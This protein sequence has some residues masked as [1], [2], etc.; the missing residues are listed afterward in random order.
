MS[1]TIDPDRLG[2]GLA[3]SALDAGRLPRGAALGIGAAAIALG[4]LLAVVL[5]GFHPVKAGAIALPSYLVLTYVA[6]NAVEGSRKAKDRVATAVMTGAFGLVM[7]P[8][9]SL[10]W[11]VISRGSTRM[12]ATFFTE[13]MRN[14]VGEGG[15]I[16]HALIGTLLVTG[17]AT[18]ISVPF[19]LFTAIY[20]VEYA[21]DSR[22]S[23]S[24][25]NMVD[26]M[27]GIPS[28]V[29][30]LFAAALFVIFQ[31]AGARSGFAGAVALAVLMTPVVVRSS[32]EMLRLVQNELREASLAL[33]VPKWKTIYKVVLPTAI[34]GILTGITLAI[35]RV[36]GETAPLLVAAGLAQDT[37]WSLFD[38]RMTTLPVQA[39]YSYTQPTLPPELSIDRAWGAAMVLIIVVAV[40]FSIA[41][42]MATVLK[43][44]GLR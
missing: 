35:A 2:T 26:V 38:G 10:V 33:G 14:V 3:P 24:I 15:G 7:I 16:Q 12:D 39:Y 18:L 27:T 30:G 44:K 1:I 6:A 28:I 41:R 37:N 8:L 19:G 20:L 23:R 13:T 9:V 17:M 36:I 25:T 42:I 22:L 11:T 32:E 4:S 43:P 40:L 21:D 34:G 31:G 29:A 5:G